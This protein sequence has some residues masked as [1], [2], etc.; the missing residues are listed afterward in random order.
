MAHALVPLSPLLPDGVCVRPLHDRVDARG[1]LLEAYRSE[2]PTGFAP[3]Q[4]NVV[5]TVAG[6]LRGPHVHP[7][8]DDYVVLV[9]GRTAVGLR[10]VR[11]GSVTEGC[12]VLLDL[13]GPSSVTIPHGVLHGIAYLEDSLEVVALSHPFDGRD[14]LRCRFDDPELGID[15][16]VSAQVSAAD[17][18]AGSFRDLVRDYAAHERARRPDRKR[19]N[20]GPR[21]T[22]KRQK[23]ST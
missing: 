14:D 5:H 20:P 22:A 4:W 9:S 1:R 23:S 21:F 10:D 19:T 3:A 11:P 2:W 6:S 12:V 17:L 15:W 18:A 8:H 13:H 16:P 7:V